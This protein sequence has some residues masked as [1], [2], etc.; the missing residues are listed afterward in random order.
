[1]TGGLVGGVAGLG[2]NVDIEHEWHAPAW[3][4]WVGN[5]FTGS[6]AP[7]PVPA[8][9]TVYPQEQGTHGNPSETFTDSDGRVWEVAEDGSRTHTDGDGTQ[10][11][12]SAP[13]ANGSV[14]LVETVDSGVPG[15]PPITTTTTMDADGNIAATGTGS[16]LD[17]GGRADS[18][19]PAPAPRPT[20]GERHESDGSQGNG[21]S[22][23]FSS[24]D[25]D[26]D[27]DFSSPF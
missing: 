7:A 26:P 20:T 17:T 15:D 9:T 23:D 24:S 10:Y 4:T 22:S 16:V 19:A 2:Q 11:D 3:M 27:G 5:L 12:L 14:T 8:T 21:A 6:P 1:M 13:D 25:G 18:P